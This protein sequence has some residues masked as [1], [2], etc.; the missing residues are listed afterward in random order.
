VCAGVLLLFGLLYP[1]AIL[2]KEAF[3]SNMPVYNPE[4]RVSAGNLAQSDKKRFCAIQSAF[5][6]AFADA[7]NTLMYRACVSITDDNRTFEQKDMAD[8]V[9]KADFYIDVKQIRTQT[10]ENVLKSIRDTVE[11]VRKV[12][13][14][15]HRIKGPVYAL[16]FQ[17]PYY[18]DER[19]G[20]A[21]KEDDR[22]I[23]VQ[24]Y[25]LQEYNWRS[26][27]ILR[28]MVKGA[29]LTSMDAPGG[30]AISIY[31]LFPLYDTSQ[32]AKNIAPEQRDELI[33]NCLNNWL[34]HSVTRKACNIKCAD[35]D[36]Y[37]CGCL[38]TDAP[39]KAYCMGPKTQ[40]DAKNKA[41]V[42]YGVLYRVNEGTTD[43][44]NVFDPENAYTDNVC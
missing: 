28:D 8:Y 40:K 2:R 36:G 32:R 14:D 10:F 35:S 5:E 11:T 41:Y 17:A 34:Q 33:N 22:V 15:A 38:N 3:N 25:S 42:T 37:I 6:P 30:V 4:L 29:P 16:L 39:Y 20:V 44:M 19:S 23:H 9:A 27:V 7:K 31:T 24:P 21:T 12:N 43:M 13:G 18:R 1:T 26:S